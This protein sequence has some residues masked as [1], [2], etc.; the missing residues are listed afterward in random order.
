MGISGV[1]IWLIRVRSILT[2]SPLTLQA[3]EYDPYIIRRGAPVLQNL[4]DINIDIMGSLLGIL[5]GTVLN[6]TINP[7]VHS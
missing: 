7:C 3:R 6:Y 2:K 4:T 1:T 5:V